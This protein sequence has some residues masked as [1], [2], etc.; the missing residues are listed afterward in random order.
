MPIVRLIAATVFL[1]TLAEG[2]A[3]AFGPNLLTNPHFNRDL[4][5]WTV[6]SPG[7]TTNASYAPGV[8]RNNASD[9]GSALITAIHPEQFIISGMTS[10][11]FPVTAGKYYRW[12]AEVFIPAGQAS[13]GSVQPA[14]RFSSDAACTH[15]DPAYYYIDNEDT[16]GQ[17]LHLQGEGVVPPGMVAAQLWVSPIKH[18]AG[19]SF[20][21]YFDELEVI[22]VGCGG[23]DS[24]TTLCLQGGRFA[25][26]ARWQT[27][28]GSGQAQAV[29]L[30][31]DT[32]Y[33]WFFN[34]ANVELVVKVLDACATFQ[35]F[36]SFS[37]GLTNVQVDLTVQD[38]LT[39]TTK[40]Y[41]NPLNTP[42]PPKLD[43]NAFSTCP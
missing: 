34:P 35:R 4:A 2:T 6:E 30:T 16:T 41:H 26:S 15:V 21:A 39:G 5:G 27:A 40:V 14:F 37:A 43:A 1:A 11:C 42:Y 33:F 20:S 3:T 28:T 10:S 17:W 24:E 31:G 18:T 8:D 32:G 13:I 29:Q 12:S 25:V 36:W 7:L 19:G 38:T 23:N 9:S 22:E